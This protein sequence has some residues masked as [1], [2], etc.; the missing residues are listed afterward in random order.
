MKSLR[1]GPIARVAGTVELP[2]SKSLSNR[3]LL[4]AALARGTT[5]VRNLLDSDDVSHMR[6]AL[7]T[8]GVETSVS[9]NRRRCI[10]RGQG[11]PFAS[12]SAELFLG[13]AGTAMR[14]LAAALCLGNGAFI[15]RGDARMHERPIGDLVTALRSAGAAIDYLGEPGFPPLQ[16]H[17][18]GLRGGSIRIEGGTSS[19]F[20]SALLMAAPLAEEASV[21]ELTGTLVSKPYVEMTCAVM[22]RFGAVIET[23]APGVYRVPGRQSYTSID[24]FA[25]EGDASS[26]SYFLAAAA[27]SGGTVRVEGIGTSATQGDVR[28]VDVL[29]RMGAVVRRSDDWL[30]V[31]GT[32]HL[33]GVE[34]D[35]RDIPDAAMTAAT[36]ALFA[37][38][39]TRIRGVAN[40][41]VKETD[42]IAAMAHELRKLGAS[43][44]EHEDG[45][46]ISPPAQLKPATIDT[47]NDHR[48]AMSFSLAALGDVT[49]EINDPGCTSKTFPDYFET[50]I[51]LATPLSRDAYSAQP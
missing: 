46:E 11:G 6:A 40:W 13:N 20:L 17:A 9:E 39:T 1:I 26:A 33:E 25:V 22:R 7:K 38:G 12:R 34:I 19:Q 51:R 47:Y 41:R 24:A 50:L 16:I 30:E 10:V 4:L 31:T 43:V 32:G 18:H 2:G 37:N 35:G 45:L 14:P 48:M 36:T 49:I 5:E 42:R 21:I 23:P 28:F 3:V 44:T 15:L 29:E 27:I 8:L